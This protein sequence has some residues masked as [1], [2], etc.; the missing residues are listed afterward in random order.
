M[1]ISYPDHSTSAYASQSS[2]YDN[3]GQSGTPG[4]NDEQTYSQDTYNQ[5]PSS[6]ATGGETRDTSSQSS[7]STS[8]QID[9]N[10]PGRLAGNRKM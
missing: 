2:P 3:Q 4:Y 8:E 5:Q 7:S 9:E 1:D 6:Y 10:Q